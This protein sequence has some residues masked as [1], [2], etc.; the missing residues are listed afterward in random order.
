MDKQLVQLRILRLYTDQPFR[1]RGSDL[2][3]A[4]TAQFKDIPLLHNHLPEGFD[5]RSPRV[6]YL[7]IRDVPQLAAFDAGLEIL[8]KIYRCGA[9]LRV[10]NKVYTITGAELEDRMVQFGVDEALHT[11]RS[12]TPWIALNERNHERFQRA[13]TPGERKSL[14]SSIITGNY[15]SLCKTLGISITERIL[16]SVQEYQVI[17]VKHLNT[18]LLGMEVVFVSNILLP[19]WIGIGKLVS[20]GFGLM[21][22]VD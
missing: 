9:R 5:Y 19:E 4:L 20:K 21:R 14:L 16:T 15:L 12:S 8:E 6:R 3:R 17:Q 1:E 18:S 7:V 13:G 11:Y 2:R 22:T 10:G